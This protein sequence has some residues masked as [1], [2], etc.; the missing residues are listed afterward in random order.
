MVTFVSMNTS[1]SVR[2]K[3]SPAVNANTLIQWNLPETEPGHNGKNVF[4]WKNLFK[5]PRLKIPS[6][7]TKWNLPAMGGDCVPCCSV[8][9]KFHWVLVVVTKSN[10]H[11]KAIHCCFQMK[12]VHVTDAEANKQTE[13]CHLLQRDRVES[14]RKNWVLVPYYQTPLRHVAH[15]NELYDCSKKVRACHW[16]ESYILT[17]TNSTLFIRK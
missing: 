2:G 1:I 3:K 8:V 9:G 6:S 11:F 10:R 12:K 7:C 4:R 16:T 15:K 5:V 14:G 13:D 17:R